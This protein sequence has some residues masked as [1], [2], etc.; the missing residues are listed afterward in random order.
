MRETTRPAVLN[1]L[2]VRLDRHLEPAVQ[3]TRGRG[4]YLVLISSD[5]CPYSLAEVE[6]LA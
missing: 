6:R 3:K 2:E 5:Q 1:G 4:R